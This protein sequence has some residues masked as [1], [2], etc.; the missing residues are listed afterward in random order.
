VRLAGR[1]RSLDVRSA[2]VT[3]TVSA[4]SAVPGVRT[5]L[6][7]WQRAMVTGSAGCVCEG[8]DIGTVVLPDALLKIWLTADP[9]AR[10]ARRLGDVD[11][12]GHDSETVRA[13]VERRDALDT[14]R[15]ADPARAA[16]DAVVL[17]TT[18]LSAD[19]VVDRV[20]AL[21][22]DRLATVGSST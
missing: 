19:A 8:R 10:V 7:R 20:L 18:Q 9:A 11:A 3:A 4:V 5:L 21:L 17:D 1:D 13:A 16:V 2:D 15:R 22:H 6:A 12:A 14:G